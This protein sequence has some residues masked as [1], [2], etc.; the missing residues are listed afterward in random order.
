LPLDHIGAEFG[1]QIHSNGDNA[2]TTF[3][4]RD[5]QNAAVEIDIGHA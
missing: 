5:L 4:M 1:D 2:R 3:A